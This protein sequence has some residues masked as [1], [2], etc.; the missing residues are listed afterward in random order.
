MAARR[1]SLLV[2]AVTVTSAVAATPRTTHAQSQPAP[3]ALPMVGPTLGPPTI[4][5]LG[6]RGDANGPAG[7]SAAPA[8]LILEPIRLAMLGVTTPMGD[9]HGACASHPEAAG[10]ATAGVP[11]FPAQSAV[12]MRL[13]PH[14]TLFGMSRLGCTLDANVG[15]AMVY[16]APLRPDVWL[17]LSAG[18]VYQPQAAPGQPAAS[19]ATLRGD[20]VFA[21]PAGRSITVGVGA[22]GSVTGLSLGGIL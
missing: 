13:V 20:F 10:T 22:T 11:G 2:V 12:A 6:A 9:A 15:A 17:A 1:L 18:A 4:V 3:A 16:A 21:R 14:L 19:R 7:R 5:W 8:S